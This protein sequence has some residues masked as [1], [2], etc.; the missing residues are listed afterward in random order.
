M[1]ESS[2]TCRGPWRSEEAETGGTVDIQRQSASSYAC[3]DASRP[4]GWSGMIMGGVIVIVAVVAVPGVVRA[5]WGHAAVIAGPGSHV[6]TCI[7]ATGQGRHEQ[8]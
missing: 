6:A 3:I 2:A 5:R 7:H 1:N 4:R 8:T